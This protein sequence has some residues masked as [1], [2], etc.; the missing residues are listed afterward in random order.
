[1]F[2]AIS[3]Y[4]RSPEEIE[5]LA[6]AHIEWLT[7]QFGSGR[8]LGSGRQVPPTGAVIIGREESLE[9]FRALLANDPFQQNGLVRY[10]VIEFTPGP[11][12]R[13]ADELDAFL[14]KPLA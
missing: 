14:R 13:R 12:P 3:T 5:A 8:F 7:R 10:A 6:P 1:M 4:L 9:A 2:I 11:P